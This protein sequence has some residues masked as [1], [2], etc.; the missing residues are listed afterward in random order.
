ML[1]DPTHIRQAIHNHGLKCVGKSDPAEIDAEIDDEL[2]KDMAERLHI[3]VLHQRQ[4]EFFVMSRH[5]L[6]IINAYETDRGDE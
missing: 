4:E 2:V 3:I 6:S 5:H 1:A